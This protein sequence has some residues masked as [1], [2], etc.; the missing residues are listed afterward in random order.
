MSLLSGPTASLI[1]LLEGS[2]CLWEHYLIPTGRSG[3]LCILTLNLN[4]NNNFFSIPFPDHSPRLGHLRALIQPG[5]WTPSSGPQVLVFFLSQLSHLQ[6][7]SPV[8]GGKVKKEARR[9]GSG[10][11]RRRA[12]AR[13]TAALVSRGISVKRLIVI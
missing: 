4:T 10:G 2:T 12:E 7:A 8:K 3:V 9:T 1:V 5:L 13:L 11:S 6:P